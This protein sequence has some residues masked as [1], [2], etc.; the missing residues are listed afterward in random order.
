MSSKNSNSIHCDHEIEVTD[1][2]SL[3]QFLPTYATISAATIITTIAANKTV[4]TTTMSNF[5]ITNAYASNQ[6]N[7]VSAAANYISLKELKTTTPPGAALNMQVPE[8]SQLSDTSTEG[9]HNQQLSAYKLSIHDNKDSK[10][11]I[12]HLQHNSELDF[13]LSHPDLEDLHESGSLGPNISSLENTAVKP[14]LAVRYSCNCSLC[15]FSQSSPPTSATAIINAAVNPASSDNSVLQQ[16]LKMRTR[17]ICITSK[18]SFMAITDSIRNAIGHKNFFTKSTQR[19]IEVTCKDASSRL[20]LLEHLR[21]NNIEH[22]THGNS[23]QTRIYIQFLHWST[24]TDWIRQELNKLGY[25]AVYVAV[26]K[27]RRTGKSLNAFNVVLEYSENVNGVFN[28]NMLGNQRIKIQKTTSQYEPPQCHRC[29]QFGH[30]KNNCH[31]PFVCVKCAGSHQWQHC[32]KP[33]NQD[34]KCANCGENHPAN[35]RG[36]RA[37]KAILNSL[38]RQQTH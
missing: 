6:Q 22:Y 8:E 30:T 16:Q 7:I 10:R 38:C 32:P 33:T 15:D 27:D 36:C 19:G 2:Q 11:N 14:H 4:T 25:R 20:K 1:T 17:P 21:I 3:A 18:S 26:D 34:A 13:G 28:V 24:P 29:Q 12:T 31:Q 23:Q 9:L 5:K 37:Y 35:Y